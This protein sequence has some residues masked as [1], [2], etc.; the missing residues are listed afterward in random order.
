MKKL[1]LVLFFTGLLVMPQML[2]AQNLLV[3]GIF[4]SDIS[5]WTNPF[6]T[7]EWV[8]D[9]G[10]PISGN[11]SMKVTGSL[12]NNG[13]FGMNSDAFSV[14]GGYWYLT[15]A[16]FK[17]PAISVSERGLFFVEWFDS[18]DQLI[19]RDEISSDYGVDDDI[20]HDL[21]GYLQAP[22]NANS[23]VM[24]LFLQTG[25]PGQLTDPFG[26]WDDAVVM[27]ETI[28]VSSFD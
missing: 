17:T 1:Y 26:L 6:V 13:T 24:R 16:S 28:F 15:A 10:A 21:D 14:Q 12:N 18:S 19:L 22:D 20:W 4:D 25:K 9:D 8:S 3:N 27:Q 2:N 23:A 11:G 7:S 5:G